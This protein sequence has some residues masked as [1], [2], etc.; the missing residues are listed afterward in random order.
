[1][2]TQ[3]QNDTKKMAMNSLIDRENRHLNYLRISITD[4]CNLRCLYC[5]PDGRIPRLPHSQIL[6]YEEI[7]RLVNI[8]IGLGISKIRITGGEPLVRK[9]AIDLLRRLTA[10]P[11]LKDVSLTTNGVLLEANAQRIFDAGIR[12]INVSLDSLQRERYAHITG[13]DMFD[14]VWA[15]IQRA[16][17]IGFA[18]IKINIVAMRGINDDE[19][20]DFG[21]LSLTY[22]FHIRFI[23]YMPIGN[24]RTRSRDQILAPEIQDRIQAL[25]ELIPVEN[26][27]N[28]GPAR[29]FRIA[30]APGEIGFISALSHHFCDRCNRLRLTADGKLRACLLSDHY[31]PFRETLRNGGTDEQLINIFKTAVS[32]KSA[33]HQ[34]C[35][36]DS[37][38][39]RDQ[40]QGIGG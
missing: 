4:R 7:L 25:G 30:G 23:E 11:Q 39:V 15:G 34:L 20:I 16:H 24:S 8:G 28:D 27:Q 3:N 10:I 2:A 1:M 33:K 31:E 37:Q 12:R 17:E 21:K 6:S 5:A 36:D 38:P 32:K 26:G 29:R 9:G 18:P 14:R 19:I 35:S 13:Y 22:P 40:M